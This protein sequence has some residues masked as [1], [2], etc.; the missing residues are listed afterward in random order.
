M[1]FSPQFFKFPPVVSP[2]PIISILK[3]S[4]RKSPIKDKAASPEEVVLNL[5]PVLMAAKVIN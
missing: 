2:L 1:S 5:A 4:L 3:P